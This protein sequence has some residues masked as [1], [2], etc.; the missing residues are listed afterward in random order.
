MSFIDC[1]VGKNSKHF[2]NDPNSTWNSWKHNVNASAC[3]TEDGF[4]YGIY[5]TAVSLTMERSI[6]TRYIFSLFWGFQVFLL[7]ISSFLPYLLY[8]VS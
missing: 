8:E 6:I 2:S 5:R 3:L 4:S 1:G 7:C